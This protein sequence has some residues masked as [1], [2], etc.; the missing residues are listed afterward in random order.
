MGVLEGCG[1]MQRNALLGDRRDC[2]EVPPAMISQLKEES[3]WKW[4]HTN[5][6]LL[7]RV[8]GATAVVGQMVCPTIMSRE[9]IVQA[10]ESPKLPSCRSA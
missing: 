7:E 6:F 4:Q 5:S 8:A 3:G 1:G 2:V 10:Q 9:I